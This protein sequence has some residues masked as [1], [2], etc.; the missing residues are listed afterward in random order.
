MPSRRLLIRRLSTIWRGRVKQCRILAVLAPRSCRWGQRATRTVF[1][2]TQPWSWEEA[3]VATTCTVARS[4]TRIHLWTPWETR[5]TSK[6]TRV[7]F[8]SP[9]LFTHLSLWCIWNIADRD[10][11]RS[12]CCSTVLFWV[13][14]I[15]I[16]M[17][18]IFRRRRRFLSRRSR[19][20]LHR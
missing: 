14:W 9:S 4:I 5:E 8:S 2:L 3:A 13:S 19:S 12:W 10:S 7:R 1:K 15:D 20:F 17:P 18:W 6:W 16:K 11:K